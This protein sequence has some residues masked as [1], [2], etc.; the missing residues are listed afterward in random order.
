MAVLDEMAGLLEGAPLYVEGRYEESFRV[1]LRV[2]VQGTPEVRLETAQGGCFRAWGRTRG[3]ACFSGGAR[4]AEALRAALERSR[5]GGGRGGDW[6]GAFRAPRRLSCSDAPPQVEAGLDEW[7]EA[8]AEVVGRLSRGP[9]ARAEARLERGWRRLGYVDT[10]GTWLEAL[11][12]MSTLAVTLLCSHDGAFRHLSRHLRLPE[13]PQD[14]AGA[15]GELEGLAADLARSLRA[16]WCELGSRPAVLHPEVAAVLIH[17]VVGHPAEKDESAPEGG[18]LGPP[19]APVASPAVTVVDGPA[20]LLERSCPSLV[21]MVTPPAA[22]FPFDDEGTELRDVAVIDE[23]R[24]GCRLYTRASARAV[25]AEPTGNGRAVDYRFP[26]LA[27]MTATYLLPGGVSPG[28]ILSSVTDGVYLRLAPGGETTIRR[29]AVTPALAYRI[30]RGSIGEPVRLGT[31]GG[32]QDRVLQGIKAV[33]NDFAWREGTMCGK[34]G[35]EGLP[36]AMGAPH[37][38]LAGLEDLG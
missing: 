29:F 31:L 10:A 7:R 15:V 11:R 1:V 36:V 32:R 21:G 20:G 18:G 30:R 19:G 3:F 26:P 8:L 34:G 28:D 38:L 14:L 33:G 2:A 4:P 5:A 24:V 16:P 35:Q 22:L 37:V 25:G 13:R 12:P 6:G 23:G 9:I 17:E 27:R